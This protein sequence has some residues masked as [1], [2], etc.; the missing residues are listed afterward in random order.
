MLYAGIIQRMDPSSFPKAYGAVRKAPGGYWYFTPS[1]KT[2]DAIYTSDVVRLLSDADRKLGELSGL[3]QILP[4]PDL[5][6]MP[7]MRRE[8]VESSRIEGTQANL[9]DL[10]LG[11]VAASEAMLSADVLEV[12]NYLRAMEYGLERMKEFPLGA[13]LLC[14]MHRILMK[15]VRG[16]KAQP[17]D[18]RQSQNWIGPSGS[19]P[20]TATYVPPVPGEVGALL[21]EWERGLHAPNALPP[22]LHIALLHWQFESIHP[23]LDGNGRIGR[24][25]ITLYLSKRGELSQPLLY[26]S[27][28]FQDHRDDYV[29]LLKRVGQDSAWVPWFSFFLTAVRKQA[30]DAI[31]S[32][33]RILSLQSAYRDR[34]H[35]SK[36]TPTTM[37]LLEQLFRNPYVTAASVAMRL[38][39]T[40]PAARTAIDRLT[41]LG[42]ITEVTGRERNRVYFARELMAILDDQR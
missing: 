9:S 38:K 14:E 22:L 35:T 24:L 41:E 19:T 12:R 25:L 4:N 40:P 15:D 10:F 37:L 26:L 18:L 3:G 31:Q 39:V 11:E 13:R 36:V 6:V 7:Y 1:L 23:F 28:Y 20:E 16:D 33:K 17:G 34:L 27:A 21:S 5:L 30:E 32:S 8:A 42:I 2:P 29:D